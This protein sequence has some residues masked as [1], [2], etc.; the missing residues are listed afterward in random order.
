MF[1]HLFR[2]ISTAGERSSVNMLIKA[3]QRERQPAD[4]LINHAIGYALIVRCL[5]N[6]VRTR[7]RNPS[8]WSKSINMCLRLVLANWSAATNVYTNRT[9]KYSRRHRGGMWVVNH[10]RNQKA[11]RP[12]ES[13]E[14]TENSGLITGVALV[15]K[16]MCSARSWSVCLAGADKA[17]SIS[18]ERLSNTSTNK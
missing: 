13:E 10:Q 1:N 5:E 12:R 14:S 17:A 11:E 16:V 8:Y 6:V 18:Y 3:K 2:F 15:P 9:Q 4:A 7:N